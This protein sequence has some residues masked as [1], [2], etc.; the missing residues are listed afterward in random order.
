M[1][2]YLV[3][4]RVELGEHDSVDDVRVRVRRVVS[5]GL[6]ELCQLIH[7]LIAYQSLTCKKKKI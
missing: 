7:G 4:D 5:Q 2:L 3:I 1:N 6:V